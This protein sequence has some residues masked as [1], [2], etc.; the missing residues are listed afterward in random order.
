MVFYLIGINLV[1]LLNLLVK[2]IV[3]S[4]LKNKVKKTVYGISGKG[5]ADIINK[6]AETFANEISVEEAQ[7]SLDMFMRKYEGVA[8]YILRQKRYGREF[9]FVKTL[10]GRKRP[11]LAL[12]GAK[13]LG[14]I[15]DPVERRKIYSEISTDER[16]CV[17]TGIQGGAA[18]I[19]AIAMRNI[20]KALRKSGDLFI[21]YRLL[22][23]IHDEVNI[24]I[25]KF[26]S[27]E[28]FNLTKDLME[29][30]VKLRIPLTVEG[31]IATNWFDAK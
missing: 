26:K 31:H 24:I 8:K 20:R 30:A 14:R 17:N 12:Q 5:L 25:K 16:R 15:E 21:N 13:N 22:S 27:N 2:G 19:V 4:L 7:E 10:V 29:N 11:L 6:E 23:Q 28:L 18:D 3:Y 9:G 1:G